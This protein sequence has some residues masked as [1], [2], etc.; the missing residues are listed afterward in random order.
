MKWRRGPGGDH[1]CSHLQRWYAEE[2]ILAGSLECV[3]PVSK[4]PGVQVREQV[5]HL[6]CCW[7]Q[8]LHG[9]RMPGVEAFQESELAEA[10]EEGAWREDVGYSMYLYMFLCLH[11][12]TITLCFQCCLFCMNETQSFFLVPQLQQTLVCDVTVIQKGWPEL[13]RI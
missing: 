1:R 5:A 13:P 6:G 12:A 3:P 9:R 8:E 4:L 10:A 2:G 7:L 11:H